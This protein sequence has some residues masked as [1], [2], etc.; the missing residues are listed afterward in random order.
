GAI[1][2]LE[3]VLG[4]LNGAAEQLRGVSDVLHPGKI[5]EPTDAIWADAVET[6]IALGELDRAR[7]I[8][9]WQDAPARCLGGGLR[10]A[11]GAG[12]AG[13]SGR[14]VRATAA[15][16]RVEAV[17]A[18]ELSLRE[19]AV[20]PFE[21]ARPLLA[22]GTTHRRARRKRAARESLEQALALFEELGARLWAQRAR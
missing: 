4:N 1:A 7:G 14:G 8:V 11:G 13:A 5:Y 16:A 22:L 20:Y 17:A 3:L 10:V 6:L 12:G 18:F 21:R 2:R 15:G 9:A 19:L